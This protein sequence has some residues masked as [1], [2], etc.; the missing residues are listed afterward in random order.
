MKS[1]DTTDDDILRQKI[2]AAD[3]IYVSDGN[4][5]ATLNYI[6]KRN[7]AETIRESVK[8]SNKAVYIGSSAGAAVAGKDIILKKSIIFGSKRRS[9]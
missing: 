5:Y 4:V 7:Q 9:F 3:F 1:D 2:S 8:G 6:H